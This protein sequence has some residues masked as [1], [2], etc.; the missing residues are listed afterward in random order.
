MCARILGFPPEVHTHYLCTLIQVVVHLYICA[1]LNYG[2]LS[3]MI[4][5]VTPSIPAI[6]RSCLPGHKMNNLIVK[7]MRF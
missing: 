5:G 7:I 3:Q 4:I 2:E 1:P 6:L